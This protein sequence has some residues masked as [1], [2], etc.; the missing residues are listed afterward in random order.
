M[1]TGSRRGK[2]GFFGSSIINV[3]KRENISGGWQ[4]HLAR[5]FSGGTPVPL[6]DL[7]RYCCGMK[8]SVLP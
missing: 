7:I 2:A 3:S 1:T 8:V 6:S 4:A 5:D